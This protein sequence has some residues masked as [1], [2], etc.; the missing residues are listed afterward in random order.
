MHARTSAHVHRTTCEAHSCF[1]WSYGEL[2]NVLC[3]K[4][5]KQPDR[6]TADADE[7]ARLVMT[8]DVGSPPLQ[9][10]ASVTDIDGVTH[11]IYTVL[12]LHSTNVAFQHD[13]QQ[14]HRCSDA[15]VDRALSALSDCLA[16]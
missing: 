11:L 4:I 5:R 8:V 1:A 15:D 16:C 13:R 3:L 9:E 6:E 10:P 14:L 12:A 7:A 2:A